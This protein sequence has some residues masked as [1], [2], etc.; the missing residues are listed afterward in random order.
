[1]PNG[2]CAWS[3]SATPTARIRRSRRARWSP[4]RVS[5]ARPTRTAR[6]LVSTAT[7]PPTSASSSHSS[8]GVFMRF[9]IATAG[10]I[11]LA[12][13][14]CSGSDPKNASGAGGVGAPIGAAGNLVINV[15][16]G[17]SGSGGTLVLGG[18]CAASEWEGEEI[19]ADLY[20][21]FDQSGSMATP[22]A[23]GT[24]LDAVRS[25]MSDFVHS[26]D[27]SRLAVGI[28]YFGYM[29]IGHTSCQMADYRTPAVA[30]ASLPGNASALLDSLAAI[31]PVGETP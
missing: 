29:P 5:I 4:E 22:T 17:D 24:R 21:M 9:E 28:G 19:P 7:S 6:H 30:I 20:V 31:S 18:A 3:A 25:A 16:Q 2:S 1:M 26:P 11:S 27:S 13:A 12:L 15:G 10:A 23:M 14:A 8:L